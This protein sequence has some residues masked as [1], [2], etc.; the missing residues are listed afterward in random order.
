[1]NL[2]FAIC[3]LIGMVHRV[4]ARPV[5][6]K[7]KVDNIV[8]IFLENHSFDNLY[9]FFPGADGLAG[10]PS[11]TFLQTDANGKPYEFLPR[12]MDNREKQRV[13]DLRFPEQLPNQP[14][15]IGRFVAMDKEIPDLVHKFYQ[16]QLQIHG[17]RNDRFAS[18][19]DA[20]G[21][22]MGYYDGRQLPLWDYARRYTLLDHFFQAAFGGSFL[23]HQWLICACTPKYH[24]A[25]KPLSAQLN[26]DGKLLRDGVLTPDGYAVNTVFAFSSP[27]SPKARDPE[28]V[29]PALSNPT[30]GDRLSEKGISW[31]WYA[32]GWNDAI[33]GKPDPTFQFH[34]QPFTYYQRFRDGSPDRAVHLKDEVDFIKAIEEGTLPAV[35]FFKPLGKYN[36]HPGYSDLQSAELRTTE[37][38]GKIE[39]SPQW[40]HTLVIVS[41]DEFGGFYDHVPPP[42]GDRWGPGSRV[43]ALLISP[44]TKKGFV[45]HTVYDTTSILSLI[46]HRFNLSPLGSRDKKAHNPLSML[47]P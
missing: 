46:E 33:A 34:H 41:Y 10:K 40:R 47:K 5:T 6:S 32:G 19:S 23:N 1:M 39:N 24:N 42:K 43:P 28:R 21:L 9:G 8:I 7:V 38:L 17:G 12:I 29:L 30:I 15:D 27:R 25:P 35:A 3:L 22:T 37:I 20:G 16:H 18:E 31:A 4:Q 2:F 11:S 14:F 13:A 45:D 44:F 26:S 36:E